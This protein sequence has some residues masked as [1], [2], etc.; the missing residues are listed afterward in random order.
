MKW[1]AFLSD[2]QRELM[3][4]ELL[5]AHV[6]YLT[7]ITVEKKLEFCGP[8]MDGT[9]IMI[10]NAKS[11]DEA[12]S[13]VRLDPFSNVSYYKNVKFVECME[14]NL[15]NGFLLEWSLDY[16]G[17]NEYKKSMRLDCHDNKVGLD[18]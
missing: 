17:S 16:M 12:K 14:A 10:L 2:K 11:E 5:E 9:A 4:I 13:I 8:L 3:T 15:K 7:Q 6:E 18:I 1:I